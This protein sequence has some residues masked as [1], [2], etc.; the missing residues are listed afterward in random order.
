ML[1]GIKP[2]VGRVSRYGVIPIT[3]DQ[4]TP[5]PDGEDGHRR[6]HRPGRGGRGGPRSERRRH[7]GLHASARPRLH[8]VPEDGRAQG[9]AH[10]HPR[11]FYYDKITAPG[12][13][14]PRGGVTPEL[15]KVMAEAIDVLKQQ[16]AVIVDPADIPSVVDKDEKNNLLKWNVCSGAEQGAGATT[17]ARS[18]SN[19]A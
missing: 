6:R 17:T 11:A 15:A 14:E 4:D 19:T 12:T 1:A 9:R 18:S 7:Q 2:T 16:G 10:R 3:A 13:T 5:G 8:E